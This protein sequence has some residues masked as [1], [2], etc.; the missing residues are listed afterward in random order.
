MPPA[1]DTSNAPALPEQIV[2]LVITA[3]QNERGVHAE[4]AI[5]AAAVLTG[6]LVLR[7]SHFDFSAL[8]PGSAI[9][10]DEVN[11]ILFEAEGQLT[12]SDIFI[13][14]LYSQGIDVS[15][16]SWPENVPDEHQVI[17]EPLEI[18][19]TIRPQIASLFAAQ[20][21]DGL[22]CAYACAQATALLVAQTRRVLDPNIGKTLAL[23]AMLRGAKTVPLNSHTPAYPANIN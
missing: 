4:T 15:K 14:A 19:A 6:E 9:L 2:M 3:L 12:V 8:T 11:H 22:E 16:E 10:S 1:S 18:V 17:M 13:N 5:S 20:Q 7:S 23:E 21:I